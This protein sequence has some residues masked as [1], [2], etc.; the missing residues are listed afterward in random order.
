MKNYSGKTG[1]TIENWR[2]KTS[3]EVLRGV[4]NK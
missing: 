3:E 2:K 1:K 4:P